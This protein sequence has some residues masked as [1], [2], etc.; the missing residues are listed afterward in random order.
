MSVQEQG[1]TEL[2]TGY[3][4]QVAVYALNQQPVVF[5]VS[6]V[7]K[8]EKQMVEIGLAPIPIIPSVPPI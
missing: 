7:Y 4:I 6:R 3:V 2:R 5:P 1:P 8:S